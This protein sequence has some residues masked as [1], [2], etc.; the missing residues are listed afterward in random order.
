MLHSFIYSTNI[1]TEYF[2]HAVYSLFF[3]LQNAV[4]FIML[5]FLVP[6]LFTFYTQ[7]VQK[8]KRKF[9]R[10]RVNCLLSSALGSKKPRSYT[11]GMDTWEVWLLYNET[12]LKKYFVNEQPGIAQ[13]GWGIRVRLPADSKR[14]LSETSRLA[15]R[16]TLYPM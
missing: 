11:A 3:P 6:V 2:K 14:F 15:L 13:S 12:K 9:R 10:Q 4:Y 1:R 5:P 8:F 16:P 7:G